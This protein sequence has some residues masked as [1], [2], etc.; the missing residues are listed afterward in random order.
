MVLTLLQQ[1]QI[2]L[3][4]QPLLS[5]K[6]IHIVNSIETSYSQILNSYIKIEIENTSDIISLPTL[7]RINGIS[8][9]YQ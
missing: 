8:N 9:S 4:M 2:N 1:Y 7:E 5:R 6:S 3:D